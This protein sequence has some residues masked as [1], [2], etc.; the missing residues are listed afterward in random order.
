MSCLEE[1][2]RKRKFS[3]VS[4]SAAR[5]EALFEDFYLFTSQR[6]F[7]RGL[8]LEKFVT[9]YWDYIT[10]HVDTAFV[11]WNDFVTSSDSKYVPYAA[12][13]KAT[14]KVS[15]NPHTNLVRVS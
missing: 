3:N 13:S 8:I 10:V 9:F 12:W 5:L 1:L 14:K 2:V 7:P 11:T 15:R 6:D 4:P